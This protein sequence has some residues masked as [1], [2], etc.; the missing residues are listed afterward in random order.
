M[1]SYNLPH[2]RHPR[3]GRHLLPS[4]SKFPSRWG[5]IS[6]VC[7]CGSLLNLSAANVDQI[8]MP[9]EGFLP[10][11]RQDPRALRL[12]WFGLRTISESKV[13]SLLSTRAFELEWKV[14]EPRHGAVQPFPVSRSNGA[15]MICGISATIATTS[16]TLT[17]PSLLRSTV[18]RRHSSVRGELTSDPRM[19]FTVNTTS[20]TLMSPSP[21]ASPDS[22]PHSAGLGTAM[23]SHISV[24]SGQQSAKVSHAE[25]HQHRAAAPPQAPSQVGGGEGGEGGGGR[26]TSV[27]S[28]QQ[29]EKDS[30]AP[31]HL[32]R[33]DS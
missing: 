11:L 10:V 8:A 7:E 28:G 6:A 20:R 23:P 27:L 31:S 19:M 9:C 1:S 13:R 24:L 21:L 30:Q 25:S 22:A 12:G 15:T 14:V 3:L 33:T 29:S 18:R 5:L 32:R 2:E 16:S 4:P 26:Q 17:A